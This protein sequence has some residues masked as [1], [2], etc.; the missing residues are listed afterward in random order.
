[1]SVQNDSLSVGW[2]FGQGWAWIW[3]CIGI[4][5]E[6]GLAGF[7]LG[8]WLC[9]HVGLDKIGAQALLDWMWACFESGLDLSVDWYV[10]WP[11]R[12]T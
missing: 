2:Y 8:V 10:A 6:N 7:Y 1:M 5:I 4:L 3:V 9:E 11:V 12:F